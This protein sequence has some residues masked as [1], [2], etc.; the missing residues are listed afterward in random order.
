V[1]FFRLDLCETK[2][3]VNK[4]EKAGFHVISSMD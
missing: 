1:Y 4:I 3:V 2:N